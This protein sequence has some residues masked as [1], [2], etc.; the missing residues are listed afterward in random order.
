VRVRGG[1]FR[2]ALALLF[3][4]LVLELLNGKPLVCGRLLAPD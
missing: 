3:L 1:D 4:K 2:L